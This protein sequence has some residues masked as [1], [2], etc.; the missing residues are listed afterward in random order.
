MKK[1]LKIAGIILVSFVGLVIVAGIVI[2]VVA[3]PGRLTK[4]V[5]HY[6][7]KFVNCE[8]EL[9]S[10]SLTFFK[11]FPNFGIGIEHVALIN[12]MDGSPNDTIANIDDLTMTLDLKQ[13]LRE[14]EL[15]IR[16]C[17]L[18]NA[19]VNIF[20][21]SVGNCNFNVF[22]IKDDTDTTGFS[23][24]Y[25]IDLE[26]ITLENSTVFFADDRSQL[27]IQ[28]KD[29]DLNLKGLFRDNDINAVLDM[30][31]DEFYLRT[32]ATPL[33]LKTVNLG[34]NGNM[35]Q[36]DQIEGVLT[37]CKPDLH[38]NANEPSLN[39]TV[40]ITLP[41]RFSLKNMS[42][43]FDQ[44]QIALRDYRLY[45]DGDAEIAENGD[46]NFN[47]DVTSN[48]MALEGLLSFLPEELQ[49][50]LNPNGSKDM[51]RLAKT[52]VKVFCYG[53]LAPIYYTKIQA[54]DLAVNMSSLPDPVMELN[55]D[56]LMLNDLSK[57][58]KDSIGI[59]N[60]ALKL[61]Q[62]NLNVKGLI[63]DLTGDVLLKFDVDGDVPFSDVKTFLPKTIQLDGLANLNL[64][65]D[66]TLDQ[67][68]KTIDDYN[69]N[70]LSAKADL[71][72]KNLAFDMS[73]IHAATPQL[74]ASLVLPN[75]DFLAQRG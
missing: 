44:G 58:T 74:N 46:P 57:M 60:L 18:E 52:N 30:N 48:D 2:A 19:F 21:D 4:T 28:V 10:A 11:T 3:S 55:L 5:K 34:F 61:S 42:G 6:A 68:K 65:T 7:P 71:K 31:M 23:F 72:I 26:E 67:L 49:K 13:F 22:N 8:M 37:L 17:I 70:R 53:S 47:M 27:A 54:N 41:L 64:T 35:K 40:S 36:F 16:H 45:V 62:S 15:V 51:L 33:T 25:L 14:K 69:L 39:D 66:F 12:P 63:D 32:F 75:T 56:M 9:G 43:H 59:S 73:T 29:F 38:L 20:T 1:A 50:T 24:D